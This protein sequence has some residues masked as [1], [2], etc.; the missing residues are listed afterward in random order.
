[1]KND[2]HNTKLNKGDRSEESLFVI[3]FV[4]NDVNIESD[5]LV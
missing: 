2:V 4:R 1:M 3:M 5:T